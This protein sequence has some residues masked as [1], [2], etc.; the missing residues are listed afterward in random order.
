[1]TID[2]TLKRHT[3]MKKM[4]ISALV[5]SLSLALLFIPLQSFYLF[6][7]K[8]IVSVIMI[9]IAFGYRDLK[10]FLSNLFYLYM[11]SITL[12]GFLYYL[13]IQFSYKNQGL[14]FFFE[15]LS[16]NYI[17]LIIIAPVILYLYIKE[18][19]KMTT[20]YNLNYEVKIFFKDEEP[21]AIN[22]FLDSG[23]RLRDPITKK[24]IILV[25]KNF[26]EKYINNKDPIY[27]P[28]KALNKSGLVK[29]FK[30]D[31]LTINNQRFTNYL[32]GEALENFNLEGIKCIL[33][34]KLMEE[35][36]LEN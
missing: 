8:N 19:K 28:Y 34:Y 2:I 21:L 18:H 9:L 35:L 27:V 14:I 25:E 1:M 7:L 5:G 32:V 30:I 31:H 15:G 26:L 20:T 16:I 3:K 29:C 6:I 33:N 13:D 23:N 10:S 22:G 36:C 17:L 24:Y 4:I 11:I 12:G